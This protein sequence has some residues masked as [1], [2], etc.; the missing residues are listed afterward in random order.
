MRASSG[1]A[2]LSRV[3]C[4]VIQPLSVTAIVNP[5]AYLT[6]AALFL[7][8]NQSA[9]TPAAVPAPPPAPA[10]VVEVNNGFGS[11][12]TAVP[13]GG[14]ARASLSPARIISFEY[15][16]SSVMP[17]LLLRCPDSSAC[18]DADQ[19]LTCIACLPE[20]TTMSQAFGTA[21][22]LHAGK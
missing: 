18:E 4:C 20:S 10:A 2:T 15:V 7:D 14:G 6:N 22:C 11:S 12:I 8:V 13:G 3:E 17:S 16:P 9:V 5:G 1:C 21:N 19:A